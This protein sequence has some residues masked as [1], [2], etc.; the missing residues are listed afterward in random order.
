MPNRRRGEVEA[1]ID[2]RP[3]T[4]VLTLGALAE[5]ETVFAATDI[6]TLAERF[7]SGRLSARDVIRI[8]ACGLHGA[9]RDVDEGE[10]SAMR[11]DGGVVGWAAL[12]ADL[13]AVTFGGAEAETPQG[14]SDGA[15][16]R[17]PAPAVP[18]D[19]ESPLSPRDVP[20]SPSPFPGTN[21]SGSPSPAG[22][23]LRPP[24]GR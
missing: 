19:R 13:L 21:S 16:A 1:I 10:V 6:A 8:V 2:G 17:S 22:A 9:G 12:V 14:R 24:S 15:D 23:S 18:A 20:G 11:I 7:A 3:T 5:L 4:L